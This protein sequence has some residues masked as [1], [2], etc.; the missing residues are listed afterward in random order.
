MRNRRREG[1]KAFY[2]LSFFLYFFL[3]FFP[4]FFLLLLSSFA[5][6]YEFDGNDG[7][8]LR[9]SLYDRRSNQKSEQKETKELGIGI[10][11]DSANV[12][13]VEQTNNQCTENRETTR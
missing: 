12:H 11:L 7:F 3:S 8:V 6:V 1:E 9:M 13:Q 10:G 4:F 2:F 5:L